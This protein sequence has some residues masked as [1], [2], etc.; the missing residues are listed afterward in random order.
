MRQLHAQR[1]P[2]SQTNGRPTSAYLG[3][4]P[5]NGELRID[6]RVQTAAAAARR[7]SPQSQVDAELRRSA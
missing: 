5:T 4:V 1:K 7:T 3:P 2:R 6:P